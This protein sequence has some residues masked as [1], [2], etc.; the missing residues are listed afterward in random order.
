[1]KI[2]AA[3]PLGQVKIWAALPLGLVK[4]WA[5][6]PLGLVLF[7]YT[8][9]CRVDNPCPFSIRIPAGFRPPSSPFL[10]VTHGISRVLLR[11]AF[12]SVTLVQWLLNVAVYSAVVGSSTC[13][14]R[15]AVRQSQQVS[16]ALWPWRQ[17]AQ[18]K[19][20]PVDSCAGVTGCL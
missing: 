6:L 5:A 10:A 14:M 17:A 9:D 11:V 2:G 20:A 18:L 1:M 16:V 7:V 4:I 19:Q 12:V 15:I 13:V 3:L 8:C